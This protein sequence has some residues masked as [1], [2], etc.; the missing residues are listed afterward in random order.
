MPTGS[1]LFVYR[2]EDGKAIRTKIRTGQRRDGRVEVVEGLQPGAQ[3]VTAG[4]LKIQRD[5]Q[6]VRIIGARE[7]P[8]PAG[9]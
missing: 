2:I 7:A 5:G 6:Q 8:A 1:E 9:G 4:Q 3:V